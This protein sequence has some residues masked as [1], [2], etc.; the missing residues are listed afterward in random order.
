[1]NMP[2]CL[3]LSS[4]V[5]AKNTLIGYRCVCKEQESDWDDTVKSNNTLP[6]ARI[7][8]SWFY[9]EETRKIPCGNMMS[10]SPRPEKAQTPSEEC[11]ESDWDADLD[12]VPDYQSRPHA[13]HRKPKLLKRHSKPIQN[14]P[15]GWP[16]QTW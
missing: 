4:E 9:P 10:N 11:M 14:P 8:R 12:Q 5:S 13:D 15:Q 3:N 1:M 7:E 16:T 2:P 6:Q